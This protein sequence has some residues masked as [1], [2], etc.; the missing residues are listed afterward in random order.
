MDRS[1]ASICVVLGAAHLLPLTSQFNL[2]E[3]VKSAKSQLNCLSADM[4]LILNKLQSASV[5]L[6]SI[7]NH[8]IC[9]VLFIHDHVTQ[10]FTLL[11]KKLK[12]KRSLTR[13][14]GSNLL[15]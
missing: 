4:I 9:G 3:G 10:C 11:K 15:E 12:L 7:I 1:M 14:V 8:C 5:Y 6:C 2:N 13:Y